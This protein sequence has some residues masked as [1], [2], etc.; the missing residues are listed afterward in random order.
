[1]FG[2]VI[3][4]SHV[5]T[6]F[7]SLFA[8]FSSNA[9]RLSLKNVRKQWATCKRYLLSDYPLHAISKENDL[10]RKKGEKEEEQK[11]ENGWKKRV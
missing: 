6:S 5:W 11:R 1:M 8:I 7:W 3:S 10:Q 2:S 9:T 4:S